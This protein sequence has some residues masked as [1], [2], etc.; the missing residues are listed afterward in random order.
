MTDLGILYQF[1]PLEMCLEV[2]NVRLKPALL[3]ILT[4]SGC[5]CTVG[6]KKKRLCGSLSFNKTYCAV[7]A[8]D[9]CLPQGSLPALLATGGACRGLFYVFF[10]HHGLW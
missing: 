7:L 5:L 10:F 4:K 6:K 3:L 8:S 2:L 9:I 1:M